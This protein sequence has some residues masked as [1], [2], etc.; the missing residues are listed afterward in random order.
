MSAQTTLLELIEDTLECPVCLKTIV[1]APVFLCENIHT[2][3]RVCHEELK[4][5]GDPCPIC[6]AK[7]T[8]KRNWNMEKILEKLP[9]TSCKFEDCNFQKV[10]KDIVK[11]HEDNCR[12]RLVPC[13]HCDQQLPLSRLSD[14]LT[15]NHEMMSN[16]RYRLNTTDGWWSTVD[17]VDNDHYVGNVLGMS[18][19]FKANIGGKCMSFYF[20][21]VLVDSKYLLI[22]GTH[23]GSKYD[24]KNYQFT[25]S[26][27]SGKSNQN[28]KRNVLMTYTGFCLPMDVSLQS[29]KDKLL[30]A[31]VSK[32][33]IMDNVCSENKMRYSISFRKTPKDD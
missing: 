25:F 12:H 33:F 27:R 2:L 1:E 7:L 32:Q 30:G 23:N 26:L 22:W 19:V 4:K 28:G 10:D 11:E 8:D 17:Y 20:N 24:N 3:C 21:S 15:G 6:R 18:N 16:D 13:Y 9:K 31:L 14:H 5:V 29:V